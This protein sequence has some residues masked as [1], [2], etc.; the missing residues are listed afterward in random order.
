MVYDYYSY[1]GLKPVDGPG[2]GGDKFEMFPL[3]N[4]VF[5]I[6]NKLIRG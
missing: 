3:N 4:N 5:Q 6:E 2:D 1:C